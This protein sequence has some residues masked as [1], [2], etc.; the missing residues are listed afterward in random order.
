MSAQL[1]PNSQFLLAAPNM[2]ACPV[3]S[4]IEVAIA[5]R[6]NAGKSS[7]VNA[8]CG[9]RALARVSRTPG[10]TRELLFFELL[11]ERRLVD[12]PGYGFAKVA[13]AQWRQWPAMIENYF[14]QRQALQGVLLIMDIRH[15][16]QPLDWHMLEYCRGAG[17]P[18]H[19]L[20]NK[21]DK[22]SRSRAQQ[23]LLAVRR[24]LAGQATTALLSCLKETG[25]EELRLQIDA[26]FAG[27]AIAP[28]TP[29]TTNAS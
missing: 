11:P 6:S 10:R 20:L 8:I 26:W 22:L 1:Y 24:E 13:A 28:A 25:R 15:P 16:L 12:L 21:A 18:V 19:V 7:A 14:R 2:A 27:E 4:G 23:Q 5:G 17:H 29:S 9:R 3:D